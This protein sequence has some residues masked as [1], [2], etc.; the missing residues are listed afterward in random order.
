M[1]LKE[2]LE[3]SIIGIS[4]T[5]MLIN[6]IY[7]RATL[8]SNGGTVKTN[9]VG[10][11]IKAIRQMETDGGTLGLSDT[12]NGTN[13]T[14]SAS[15]SNNLDI[16]M[17][18]NTEYG[19]MAILSASAYG[20]ANKI[21]NGQTTTGNKS[22]IVININKEW[23]AAGTISDDITFYNASSKY[24]NDMTAGRVGEA[25]SETSGWHGSG[26][27][28]WIV[29]QGGQYVYLWPADKYAGLIR[30]YSG[31]IFSYYGNGYNNSNVDWESSA[32]WYDAYYK[33][34]YASRAVV[35]VG[36]GF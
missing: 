9:N 34:T 20:N 7:S 17:E 14:S 23:V 36:K 18:K 27:S 22:G 29:S 25:C 8:Q 16:H 30:A 13:L 24:K 32:R 31:S 10:T 26:A 15:E 19:A 35:V 2:K 28:T 4:I 12:V 6:P 5:I 11:W 3:I 21:E 1:K 33:K